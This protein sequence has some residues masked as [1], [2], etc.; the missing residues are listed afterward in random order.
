MR[1]NEVVKNYTIW[2]GL[3]VHTNY[4]CLICSL[5]FI[6]V[7]SYHCTNYIIHYATYTIST[8]TM[9]HFNSTEKNTIQH[10]RDSLKLQAF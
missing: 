8:L 1:T 5:G 9:Q 4:K 2:C 3:Y 6:A 7:F 10:N